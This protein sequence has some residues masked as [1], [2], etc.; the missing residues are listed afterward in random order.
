MEEPSV[1]WV[2]WLLSARKWSCGDPW[3]ADVLVSSGCHDKCHGLGGSEIQAFIVLQFWKLEQ[4]MCLSVLSLKPCP[5][6]RDYTHVTDSRESL[7]F[8]SLPIRRVS[9]SWTHLCLLSLSP[10]SKCCH[11]GPGVSPCELER[12]NTVQS[13]AQTMGHEAE[14][15]GSMWAYKWRRR[16]TIKMLIESNSLVPVREEFF[17]HSTQLFPQ[18]H[19]IQSTLEVPW[20]TVK[21]W[22]HCGGLLTFPEAGCC[23]TQVPCYL[24]LFTYW[25]ALQRYWICVLLGFFSFQFDT[26]LFLCQS[27]GYC[28]PQDPST[29]KRPCSLAQV[30]DGKCMSGLGCFFR[31]S[32]LAVTCGASRMSFFP[33]SQSWNDSVIATSPFSQ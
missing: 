15:L 2:V 24:I 7:V 23:S 28:F 17:E 30:R 21:P 29:N 12:D 13:L 5:W 11:P 20:G 18:L 1:R 19:E 3:E 16:T 4:K 8:W 9:Y 31:C 14:W 6:L 27:P 33:H 25:G 22:S 10:I 26:R 32:H